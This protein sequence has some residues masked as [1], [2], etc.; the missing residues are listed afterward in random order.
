[1]NKKL[2]FALL[3]IKTQFATN[4]WLEVL[5]LKLV[6]VVGLALPILLLMGGAYV[7]FL[8]RET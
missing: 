2:L 8:R 5:R 4:T 3:G 7:V 1:M 6:N